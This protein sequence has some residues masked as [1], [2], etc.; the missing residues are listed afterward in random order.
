MEE[1]FDDTRLLN[2]LQLY[3]SIRSVVHVPVNLE[4][5]CTLWSNEDGFQTAELTITSLYNELTIWLCRRHLA[6]KNVD[7]R[8]LSKRNVHEYCQKE[9]AFLEYLACHGMKNDTL[10]IE[11]TLLQEALKETKYTSDHRHVLNMGVLKSVNKPGIGTRIETDKNHYFAQFR[12]QEY[13]AARYLV[14]ALSGHERQKALEFIKTH[15]CNPRFTL[16]FT[17]ASG[18]LPPNWSHSPISPS[19]DIIRE[20]LSGFADLTHLERVFAQKQEMVNS[21]SFHSKTESMASAS[22]KLK[23]AVLT[24]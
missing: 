2:I 15:R 7:I 1:K 4:L 14:N 21:A 5:L 12:F 13:F 8:L 11:S 23:P 20:V 19:W 9:L 22:K 16:V 18:L 10:I 6:A 3:P 17:F 24:K